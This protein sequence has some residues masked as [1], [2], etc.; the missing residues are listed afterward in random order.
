MYGRGA[1]GP[2]RPCGFASLRQPDA[3]GA[4]ESVATATNVLREGRAPA[5]PLLRCR[6]RSSGSSTLPLLVATGTKLPSTDYQLSTTNY[7]FYTSTWPF[8]TT[9]RAPSPREGRAPARPRHH[10]RQLA[11]PVPAFGRDKRAPPANESI[12]KCNRKSQIINR[13]SKIP[14]PTTIYIFYTSCL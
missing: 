6:F 2:L 8:S 5:R 4:G 13:K 12:P 10:T 14:L 7:I 11:T 3:C 1:L 9:A